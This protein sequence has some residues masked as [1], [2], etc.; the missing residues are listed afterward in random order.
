MQHR[1]AKQVGRARVAASGAGKGELPRSPPRLPGSL[2]AEALSR[3]CL[4]TGGMFKDSQTEL[5]GDN[6]SSIHDRL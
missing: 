3:A 1:R 2:L 4:S 6:F 5:F